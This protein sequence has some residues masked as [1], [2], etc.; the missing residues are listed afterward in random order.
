MTIRESIELDVKALRRYFDRLFVL[1]KELSD[2]TGEPDDEKYA[3]DGTAFI[4]PD[5][6]C[7]IYSLV[8]FRLARLADFHKEQGKLPLGYRDIKGNNDLDAYHKY[9]TR[10]AGL[11]LEPVASS[12]GELHNLRN[13]RNCLIHRGGHVEA[14][15][16]AK[17]EAIP[18]VALSGTLV[19]LTDDFIWRSLEHA[20]TYLYAVAEAKALPP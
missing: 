4:R 6:A 15:Q 18:G 16:S 10:V 13:V 9:F 20:S 17:I 19:L 11:H 14:Q 12:L 8:D 3:G 1:I 5:M 7:N 2:F